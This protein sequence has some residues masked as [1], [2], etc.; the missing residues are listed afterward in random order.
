[1]NVMAAISRQQGAPFSLEQVTLDAPRA[2]E[3]IVRVAG[4]GLCHSDLLARDGVIP[5]AL[6]AVFGHEGSGEVVA[7]GEAVSNIKIG[8]L[9]VMS[10]DSCHVCSLCKSGEPA[11]CDSMGVLNN[12]GR[13]PDGTTAIQCGEEAIS[14]HFFGQS[15][16]ANYAL[17]TERNAI[18][19]PRDVPV[20]LMGPLGCGIQTGAGAVINSLACKPGSSLLISGGGS[21]GLSALLAAILNGCTTIIVV[22]PHESRRALALALG[23]THVIDPKSVDAVVAIRE[24][25]PKGVDYAFDSTGSPQGVGVALASLGKRGTLALAGVPANSEST[26]AVALLPLVAFGQTVKGVVEGDS[27][28]AVFIPL[29]IDLYKQGRFP[30]DRLIKTYPFNQI[31]EAVQDHHS[32]KCVKA[33]LLP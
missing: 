15:S 8:D 2:D 23:A 19:I 28:P 10:F 22:E 12:Y 13:R 32:G 26:A 30:F 14:S 3:I 33:V 20:E 27:D 31:N 18:V 29:L 11:Y 25:I 16:F 7:V 5:V 21:L 9:V 17:C 1:M 6:P 24:V 4:V